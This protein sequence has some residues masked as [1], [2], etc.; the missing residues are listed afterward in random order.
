MAGSRE[1]VMD[2]GP[3]LASF[4]RRFTFAFMSRDQ[5]HDALFQRQCPLQSSVYGLPGP[6][7]VVTV[8]IENPIRDEPA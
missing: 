1:P 7:Q 8:Q 3:Y 5:E 2:S 4:E 6:I